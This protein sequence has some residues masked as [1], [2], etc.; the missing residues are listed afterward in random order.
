MLLT[1]ILAEH[2]GMSA[3]QLEP[4]LDRDTFLS[5]QE[6]RELGLIDSI[7]IKRGNY[8]QGNEY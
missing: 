1:T 6:A 3:E 4:L 5:P 8:V 2:S 7:I